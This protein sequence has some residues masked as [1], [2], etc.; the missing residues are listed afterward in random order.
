MGFAGERASGRDGGEEGGG[1]GA[2]E[3]GDVARGGDGAQVEDRGPAGDQDQIGRAGC[4][5]RGGFGVRCGVDEGEC[6]AVLAGGGE[7]AVEAC[8]LG[9]HH[10][11]GSAWQWSDQAAL[12]WG[13]LPHQARRSV[14][15]FRGV[16]CRCV[17]L[18]FPPKDST[19]VVSGIPG[20]VHTLSPSC[21]VTCATTTLAWRA[22]SAVQ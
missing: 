2:G 22:A 16:S 18:P 14:P 17:H 19:S 7:D 10:H 1:R 8:G 13:M 21:G 3:G 20:A 11:G 4:G 12:A 5:Q 6:C 15:D 9:G